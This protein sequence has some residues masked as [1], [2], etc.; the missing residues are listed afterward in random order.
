VDVGRFGDGATAEA[1]EPL[2]DERQV[3]APLLL[4]DD[5]QDVVP[6]RQ[7]RAAELQPSV[8]PRQEPHVQV[9]R[10]VAPAVDVDAGDAVEGPD[11]SL[12]PYR[13]H[14]EFRGQE[15]R[16]VADIQV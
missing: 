3:F 5:R 4:G 10:A 16:Q 6:E 12:E 7:E 11:R 9:R 14:A 13:H 8:G 15:V 2:R 1:G